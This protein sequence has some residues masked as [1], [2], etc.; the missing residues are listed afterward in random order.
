M[1]EQSH[2]TVNEMFA[3][4]ADNEYMLSRLH[5]YICQ[6]LPQ[7]LDA[8]H[9][10]KEQRQQRIEELTTEQDAFIKSFL[11]NN[12][13][14]YN[15][16]T[17]KFF[18]YDGKTYKLYS[19]DDILYHVL[20]SITND[21]QLM[22]WKQRTKVYIMKRIKEN[23][24]TRSVPESHTIQN[25]LSQFYP[26][27]FST[28]AEAKYFLTILGDNI[29]KKNVDLIHFIHTNAKHFIRELNTMCQGFLGTNLFQTIKHKYHEH[30]YQHCRILNIHE[31]VKNEST[32]KTMLNQHA[33][34]ILCVACHYSIR[35]QHSDHFVLN[36]CDDA[37]F[38]RD[39]FYLK[40]N[41][42]ETIIQSFLTEYIGDYSRSQTSAQ[43]TW[44]NMQYLW[45]HFL[46]SKHLPT[47]MFQQTFKGFVMQKVGG[48]YKEESDAFVGIC[49][50][51]LPVIQKFTKFWDE[52]I[53]IDEGES[54]HDFEISEI[55]TLFK[56]W[57][58]QKGDANSTLNQ[59]QLLDLIVYFYPAVEIESEKYVYKIR[60]SMWDKQMTIQ[61]TIATICEQIGATSISIYDAYL[62]Y[63]RECNTMNTPLIAS[64]SYF[65]KYVYE[66]MTERVI[67]G[68]YLRV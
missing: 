53:V 1:Q 49:S 19:E 59:S 32:W 35:Y 3:K 57:C 36:H 25:V 67:D 7:S 52:T 9:K 40:N 47:I 27:I 11:N 29:F 17:E 8:I 50:K 30:N 44:K 42:P 33:L 55:H 54:E 12:Q 15:V 45:K 21:K 2:T 43:I 24:L 16:S 20:S 63:C 58:H 38:V 39:V 41:E 65:E 6:Q 5:N 46:E 18:F 10:S 61:M 31:N 68:N 14:F 23:A 56:L 48:F 64:K 22:S 62:A 60:S 37:G 34:D 13:Y 28:K 4:Y 51:F 26:A 66:N